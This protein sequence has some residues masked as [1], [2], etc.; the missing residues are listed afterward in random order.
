MKLAL[1]ALVL[2][3]CVELVNDRPDADLERDRALCRIET[4]AA[5]NPIQRGINTTN[6]L[7]YRYGW[8]RKAD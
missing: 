8:K 5:P 3:G 6:C 2:C 7:E 4:A 1:L